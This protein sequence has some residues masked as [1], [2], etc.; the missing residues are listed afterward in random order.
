MMNRESFGTWLMR[1]DGAKVTTSKYDW[2][3]VGMFCSSS[4]VKFVEKPALAA[5]TTGASPVTVT[6]SCR[7]P[8]SSPTSTWMVRPT[9]TRMS[10]RRTVVNPCRVNTSV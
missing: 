10:S 1:T 6:A 9:S 3:A 2:R 5:S 8:T 7:L 4:L